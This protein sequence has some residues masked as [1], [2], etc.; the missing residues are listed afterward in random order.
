[1]GNSPH[2]A[3]LPVRVGERTER[4][5]EAVSAGALQREDRLHDRR[6]D[7]EDD[8]G[9]GERDSQRAGDD[10]R[11][12]A[13]A[14]QLEAAAERHQPDAPEGGPE[15][16]DRKPDDVVEKRQAETAGPPHAPERAARGDEHVARRREPRRHVEV[17]LPR[18]PLAGLVRWRQLQRC[19]RRGKG[20]R[21]RREHRNVA[22]A[23]F[24]GPSRRP[25]QSRRLSR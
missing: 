12:L 15:H 8:E 14:H 5:F 20:A 23:S 4:G 25:P 2:G 11:H 18:R 10:R 22:H 9:E 7:E 17:D 21:G 1:M 16:P 3:A 24:I 13:H 19:R 6:E